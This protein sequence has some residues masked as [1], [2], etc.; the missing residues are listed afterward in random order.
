VFAGQNV[1]IKEISEQ[2]WLVTFMH[3][4]LGFFDHEAGR[5][6]CADNPFD[7]RVLAVSVGRRNTCVENI[8]WGFPLQ[9]LPWSSI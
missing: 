3:Y 4:D 5:V 9:R 8:R 2:I 1:G 6:E 7:P